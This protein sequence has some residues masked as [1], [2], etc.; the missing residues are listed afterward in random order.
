V[1]LLIG[2]QANRDIKS[3]TPFFPTDLDDQ[4]AKA[5]D[6]QFP[7]GWGL[8]VRWHDYRKMLTA[9]NLDLLE[10]HLSY[11]DMEENLED[12]FDEVLDIDFTVHS[13]ELF[14]GDHIL[15]LTADDE[16]YRQR[17]IKELQR[18]CDL[19][20]DLKKWHGKSTK[21]VIV[22]NMGG[23]KTEGFIPVEERAKLYARMEESLKQ[24]NA[25]GV[26]IIPQTMPP[27]PWHFGGQSHHNLFMDPDEI[28]DFCQR[29][30]MRICFDVSHSQLACNYFGWSMTE[31]AK[32]VGPYT[33]HLHIVDA[34]GVDGEGLQ[35][36]DGN[37]D[38][39]ALA[40]E[41]QATCPQA[42][43]IP[44]IWQGHKNN[45]AGFWYALDKLEAW[46]GAAQ[47]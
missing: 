1:D 3:G 23:F 22:T 36:G 11:K 5:R 9:T 25:E 26:E 39:A 2:K 27:F 41:L 30:S 44:E 16:E 15:D 38:F 17:S 46:F 32:K 43:F 13:P 34:E 47:S 14:A 10:Y 20:R 21:P 8:P 40:K 29:N 35:I 12:W 45:G 6:Y 31:F 33:A 37:M 28:V 7:Q 18:V 24:I 42:T 4:A 19:T